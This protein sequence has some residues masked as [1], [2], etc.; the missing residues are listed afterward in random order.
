[1]GG[2]REGASDSLGKALQCTY[3]SSV[4]KR[5]SVSSVSQREIEKRSMDVRS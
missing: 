5:E 1:M 3:Y 2:E 4:G